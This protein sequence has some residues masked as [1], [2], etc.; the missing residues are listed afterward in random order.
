MESPYLL[1]ARDVDKWIDD[2]ALFGPQ[3]ISN[4]L[5]A[6]RPTNGMAGSCG[7]PRF[8]GGQGC[9]SVYLLTAKICDS[10]SGTF[11]SMW[12]SESSG[13]GCSF[14]PAGSLPGRARRFD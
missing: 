8:Y 2:A 5:S 9:A 3:F 12:R 4:G 11:V 10:L 14:S 7:S 13:D 1:V 6:L